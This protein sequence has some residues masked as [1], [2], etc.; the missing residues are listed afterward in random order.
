MRASRPSLQRLRQIKE[1]QGGET[2]W[3]K[4]YMPANQVNAREAPSP[5]RPSG[6]LAPKLGWRY[7]ATQGKPERG[8]NLLALYNP[9]VF[10]IH[11]QKELRVDPCPH[12]LFGH[13]LA[14]GLDLPSLAGTVAVADRLG[15]L[16]RH[17]IIRMPSDS[18]PR[19]MHCVPFPFVG[20]SLLFLTD[21]IGPYCVNWDI[22]NSAKDFEQPFATIKPQRKDKPPNKKVLQR[23]EIEEV[24][25][26][27]GFIPTYRIT[28][29]QIDVEVRIN[30]LNLQLWYARLPL[31]PV[32]IVLREEILVEYDKLIGSGL[33]QF[34]LAKRAAKDHLIDIYD[35]KLILKQGIWERRLRVDLFRPVMED[36]PLFRET[37]DILDVYAGWFKRLMP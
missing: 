9:W 30:L 32:D 7:F 15:C 29:D 35:A 16:S 31:S 23:H 20:D 2:R 19:E 27:D 12:P 33:P 25:Y 28:L 14:V 22:K 34:E 6:L 3:G 4:D 18:D 11:E 10:E 1:R 21:L 24:Y 37:R 13:P 8:V 36:Q 26:L 17:P 5:S